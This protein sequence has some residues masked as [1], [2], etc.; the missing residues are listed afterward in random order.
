MQN[1]NTLN[2]ILRSDYK[3]F[4]GK[5]FYE[6]NPNTKF[7]DSWYIDLICD[8]LQKVQE[9]N[10]HRFILNIPPRYLKSTICSIAFPAYLLGIDPSLKIMC[11]SYSDELAETL[12]RD[13]KRIMESKWYKEVFPNTVIR[14]EQSSACDF[15]T[16][17]N[18]GKFSTGILGAVTGRGAD[19]III[20]D[21]IK[22]G[23][24]SSERKLKKINELFSSAIVSRLNDPKN[25]KIIL[26]MQRLHSD[27]LSGYLINS[28]EGKWDCLK[29]P[30]IATED[31]VHKIT[32]RSQ[33]QTRTVVRKKGEFLLPERQNK[34]SLEISDDHIFMAQY[35]QNPMDLSN[36][37][38]KESDFSYYNTE[39]SFNHIILS[40]DTASSTK[41]G[42]SFSVGVILGVDNEKTMYLLEVVRC[43]DPFMDLCKK[44]KLKH[45]SYQY[46]YLG[47][48]IT[49]LIE[50]ASSGSP[51]LN[52]LKK[53]I[54]ELAGIK[55]QGDKEFRFS[56]IL[57]RLH[58][59][60]LLFP[61]KANHWW[62][63]FKKEILLFP[64]STFKDQCDALSQAVHYVNTMN[65][66][67][68]G[69]G[70]NC[71]GIS[72]GG[73]FVAY[74]TPENNSGEE[75]RPGIG[76]RPNS[77]YGHLSGARNPR[78]P[79]SPSDE[80]E[81]QN[82]PSH[83]Q[84]KRPLIG[85]RAGSSTPPSGHSGTVQTSLG[86]VVIRPPG[87]KFYIDM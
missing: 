14:T 16:T 56:F 38:I 19:Y 45:R 78:Y 75:R 85:V 3:S 58:D 40:W 49:T 29:L 84:E 63:P 46:N 28:P 41:E 52:I 77:S 74:R 18:G 32:Y 76:A 1:R 73:A 51:L 22:A 67:P 72:G 15:T 65:S 61:S 62:E 54:K 25:G 42:S 31:E 7:I 39:P 87:R 35:Q 2:A 36:G 44:I 5:S 48:K 4:V 66:N 21:P 13:C 55:P 69:E 79:Q 83:R 27:D 59:S 37:L 12:A 81:N 23:E 6:L 33:K 43:R 47:A 11:L 24:A 20:D 57:P 70:N 17:K 60:T 10:S 71:I 80:I 82:G 26:V 68:F 8:R 53:D 50:D 30:L 86:D 34:D 64:N 9:G